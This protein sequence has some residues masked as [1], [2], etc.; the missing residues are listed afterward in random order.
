VMSRSTGCSWPDFR[1]NERETFRIE[2]I[3]MELGLVGACCA[4]SSFSWEVVAWPTASAVIE[5]FVLR[6]RVRGKREPIPRLSA[7]T[8]I[9]AAPRAKSSQSR[10]LSC[11]IK[12]YPVAVTS[13]TRRNS[14]AHRHPSSAA[15]SCPRLAA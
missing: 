5:L 13:T 1:R 7:I 6:P 8:P 2:Q 11:A 9:V 15:T 12:G 3:E 14:R 10:C 4:G